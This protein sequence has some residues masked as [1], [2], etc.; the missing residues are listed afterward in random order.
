MGV[1]NS[2]ENLYKTDNGIESYADIIYKSENPYMEINR[3]IDKFVIVRLEQL[4]KDLRKRI[5]AIKKQVNE[6]GIE[7]K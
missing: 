7:W 4:E 5:K 6:Y 2:Y 1:L 3:L